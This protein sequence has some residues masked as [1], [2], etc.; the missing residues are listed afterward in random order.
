MSYSVQWRSNGVRAR[1][2]THPC[3]LYHHLMVQCC[4]TS[5][6][7]RTKKKEAPQPV[8]G[9]GLRKLSTPGRRAA[10]GTERGGGGPWGATRCARL[11]RGCA[12]AE[13]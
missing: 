4:T 13:A 6:V 3:V 2:S 10:P 1:A 8:T 12:E 9:D 5:R 11:A 7:M